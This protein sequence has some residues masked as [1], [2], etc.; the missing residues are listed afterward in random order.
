MPKK[1]EEVLRCFNEHT[2]AYHDGARIAE[3]LCVDEVLC[4]VVDEDVAP[5]V[6][7]TLGADAA[8]VGDGLPH[9]NG[10]TTMRERER[11][12]ETEENCAPVFTAMPNQLSLA[13]HFARMDAL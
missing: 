8:L 10:G 1:L 2:K 12:R 11:E 9:D 5:G 13:K 6:S 7:L 3:V 4:V